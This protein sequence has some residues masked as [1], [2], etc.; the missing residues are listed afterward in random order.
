MKAR[1]APAVITVAQ[2]QAGCV[3]YIAAWSLFPPLAI[4]PLWR[5]LLVVAVA[6]FFGLEA[7]RS[8]LGRLYNWPAGLVVAFM[9]YTVLV[10]L[11]TGGWQD[12][13]RAVQLHIVCVCALIGIAMRGARLREME[14][15]LL[16]ILALLAGA[17][18]L[19][20]IELLNN[21]YAAR[22]VVRTSEEAIVLLRAGVGGYQLVYAGVVLAPLLALFVVSG[23]RFEATYVLMLVFML[24]IALTLIV[25]AGYSI[26]LAIAA[27]CTALALFAKRT[28]AGGLLLQVCAVVA[29]AAGAMMVLDPLLAVGET[30]AEGT[31]YAKK[32]ADLRASLEIGES[33]GTAFDR[34]E[35]YLHSLWAFLSAPVL[36]MQVHD[37][38]GDHSQLLDTFARYGAP[39]GVIAITVLVWLPAALLPPLPASARHAPFVMML[40]I[41]LFL[42]VNNATAAHG[43]IAFLVAPILAYS[44]GRRAFAHRAFRRSGGREADVGDVLQRLPMR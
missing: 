25:T 19:T 3:L 44:F 12:V 4:D 9:A 31:R 40:A 7:M 28:D 13:I 39:I 1:A 36:G 42:S 17:M 5:A 8:G 23:R 41:G 10:Q 26:A 38:L 22:I 6:G 21:P 14:W 43:A 11:L 35:R 30:M 2:L 18:A 20:V 32:L 34:S 37:P 29:I 24:A 27:L 33:V 16:P 15:T